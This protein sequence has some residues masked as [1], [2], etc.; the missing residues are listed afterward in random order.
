MKNCFSYSSLALIKT[1]LSVATQQQS[2]QEL[3]DAT[4]LWQ[5]DVRFVIPHCHD[6]LINTNN[7]L[8]V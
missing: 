7:A 3:S 1:W 6:T 8:K 4:S 5:Q 2:A